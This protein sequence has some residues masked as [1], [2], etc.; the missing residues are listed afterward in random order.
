MHSISVRRSLRAFLSYALLASW[1]LA[2]APSRA[3]AVPTQVSVN[4]VE[5]LARPAAM[6][7]RFSPTPQFVIVSPVEVNAY[8]AGL[9]PVSARFTSRRLK[10]WRSQ[11]KD[12]N[13]QLREDSSELALLQGTVRVGRVGSDRPAAAAIID[14]ELEVSF[15]ASSRHGRSEMVRIRA[16]GRKSGRTRGHSRRVPLGAGDDSC[17]TKDSA[18][19]AWASAIQADVNASALVRRWDVVTVTDETWVARFGSS[20]NSRIASILNTV[21]ALYRSQLGVIFN[22]VLAT[23]RS[24]VYT[25]SNGSS[26][27]LTNFATTSSASG[28]GVSLTSAILYVDRPLDPDGNG[29]NTT[30]GIAYLGGIC[31]QDFQY[32]L[33][34]ARSPVIEQTT[35][36]ELGHNLGAEHDPTRYADLGATLMFP[37]SVPDRNFTFSDFSR[38]QMSAFLSSS[39]AACMA[40]VDD[41]GN[42]IDPPPPTPTVPDDESILTARKVATGRKSFTVSGLLLSSDGSTPIPSVTVQLISGGRVVSSASTGSDGRYSFRVTANLR[43]GQRIKARVVVPS[44]AIQSRAI[45]FTAPKRRGGRR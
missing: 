42:P 10:T 24:G 11:I 7:E 17:A 36:H 20:S 38:S 22:I 25:R 45:K 6:M 28:F 12:A 34:T 2:G 37:S 29:N 39:D 33:L 14:G 26:A 16:G 15:L 23:D 32:A 31:N 30:N 4:G 41:G 27:L 35:G 18:S 21:D 44:T 8:V 3:L 19:R 40:S 43:P 13:G 9:G 1:C 5:A